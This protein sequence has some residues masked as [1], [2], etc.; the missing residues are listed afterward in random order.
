[1]LKPV[2]EDLKL[3]GITYRCIVVSP[4]G[5]Q[6]LDAQK[7]YFIYWKRRHKRNLTL[8][9]HRC[10]KTYVIAGTKRAWAHQLTSVISG[11]FSAPGCINAVSPSSSFPLMLSPLASN[12]LT[13][14]D[15]S[16]HY[17]ANIQLRALTHKKNTHIKTCSFK[18]HEA[19]HPQSHP[20]NI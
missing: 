6:Y 10:H 19:L 20:Y 15:I 1:M 3:P 12:T 4:I 2:S 13:Q 9:G 7:I 14:K 11:K 16:I 8:K 17:P 18:Y 5:Q